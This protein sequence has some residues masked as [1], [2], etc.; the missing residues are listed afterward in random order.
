M[1]GAVGAAQER[2]DGWF[3]RN[4]S[5][6]KNALR[7]LFGVIWLIDGAFKFQPGFVQQFS[8][9]GDGAPGWL[10]G[11]YSY[12]GNTVNPNPAPWV[13]LV[14]TLEILLGLA[15]LFGFLRKIAYTGGFLLSLFIW[16]VP[17]RFGGPYGPA[18]TDIGT[19]AVYAIG[20][21]FLLVLDATYGTDRWTLDAL[22]ERRWPAWARWSAIRGFGSGGH[23]HPSAASPTAPPGGGA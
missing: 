5:P 14:G 4:A 6:I 22:I 20:F 11:W 19:G 10:Q 17:E 9:S 15:L 7:M 3:V 2:V 12:W 21:L 23:G 16:A 13:Y 18:S 1:A 8:V